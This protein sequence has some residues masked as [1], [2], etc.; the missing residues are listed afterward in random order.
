MIF[1]ILKHQLNIKLKKKHSYL[2]KH[3]HLFSWVMTTCLKLIRLPIHKDSCTT[4]L[5]SEQTCAHSGCLRVHY[6]LNR[7]KFK[8][9]FIVYAD[10]C[11]ANFGCRL[12]ST[13]ISAKRKKIQLITEMFYL[14]GV[15]RYLETSG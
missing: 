9:Y 6:I 14:F 3:C 11:Q 5:E 15:S 12:M 10:R 1:Q 7:F 4:V 2:S 8:T 13:S